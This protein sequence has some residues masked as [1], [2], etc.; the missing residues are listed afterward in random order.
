M[1]RQLLLVFNHSGPSIFV[2]RC[3]TCLVR[4]LTEI[5]MLRLPDTFKSSF[6][7]GGGGLLF[8]LLFSEGP[9]PW[10]YARAVTRKAPCSV[11]P[12]PWLNALL[13]L[14]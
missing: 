11:G 10:A 4:I 14:S 5:Y 13:S 3:V 1:K 7:L 8:Y 6:V 12:C 2:D 9:A